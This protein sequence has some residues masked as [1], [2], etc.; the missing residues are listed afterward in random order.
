MNGGHLV[1]AEQ[2]KVV[3]PVMGGQE[4]LGLAG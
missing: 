3:D 1:A 4:A 2:E